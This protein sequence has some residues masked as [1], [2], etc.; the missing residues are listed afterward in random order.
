MGTYPPTCAYTARIGRDETPRGSGFK[1]RGADRTNRA[2]GHFDNDQHRGGRPNPPS[3]S[4]DLDLGGRTPPGTWPTT[5]T[6]GP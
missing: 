2:R 1:D 6:P 5:R 3:G 4:R